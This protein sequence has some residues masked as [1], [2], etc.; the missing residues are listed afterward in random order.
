MVLFGI[1]DEEFIRDKVPMTKSEIRSISLAKLGLLRDSVIY[2]IGAGTGSVSVEAA[3]MA[4]RG[5]IF[6]IEKKKEAL[7]LISKNK[8]KF[9]VK[10]LQIIEGEAPACMEGLPVATHAFVGGT[11]GS[12]KEILKVLLQKNPDIRVVINTISIESLGE[13]TALLKN[14]PVMDIEIVQVGVAKSKKIGD[15]HLMMG[16][17]PVTIISFTGTT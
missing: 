5:R 12:M 9:E 2:D 1:P 17:N 7:E 13:V 14:L 6:A 16:Q 8:L 3:R 4:D 11:G 10:N 15:Y